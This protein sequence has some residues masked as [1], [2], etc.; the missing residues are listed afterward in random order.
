M[1]RLWIEAE[2]NKETKVSFPQFWSVICLDHTPFEKEVEKIKL[3]FDKIDKSGDGLLDR[4]EIQ[5][6]LKD[7]SINWGTLGVDRDSYERHIFVAGTFTLLRL[8]SNCVLIKIP[9]C[10]KS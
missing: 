10:V 7:P 5:L 3:I 6:A 4:R 1:Q 2:Q 8:T 9:V